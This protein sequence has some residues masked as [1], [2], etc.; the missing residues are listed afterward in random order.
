MANRGRRGNYSGQRP[1]GNGYYRGAGGVPDSSARRRKRRRMRLVRAAAVWVICILVVA[2]I[3]AGTVRVTSSMNFSK[4]KQMRH[5]GIEKM[6]S[7]D[8]EDAILEFDGALEKSG[9]KSTKF[10]SDV[11][12]YRAE[13]EFKLKDYKASLHTYDLLL[14]L[15]PDTPAY[16]YAESMC[17]AHMG[18]AEQALSSYQSGTA[19]EKK[20]KPG[21]GRLEALADTGDALVAAKEYDK[22][23]G[24][25]Q[26]GL[27]DG[28]ESGAL[29]NQT[30]ICQLAKEDYKGAL[31]SFEKGYE[32]IMKEY[33]LDPQTGP[34]GAGAALPESAGT[35]LEL[36]KELTYN[37]AAACEYLQEY[38]KAL[39]LFQEYV[40][41]F[42]S[43]DDAEHEIAFLKTR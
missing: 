12:M 43:N 35:D 36:L 37:R 14:K 32:A 27:K 4:K 9:K 40:S 10:N 8:Y 25:Y 26:D 41:A 17:H 20:G 11:L 22:A 7:G 31:D 2:A 24:L 5:E 21:P 38:K 15:E 39:D 42:G 6:A 19:L 23:L 13:A 3:A 29:Y 34:A 30:G 28:M 18:D 1:Q 33:S 16:L